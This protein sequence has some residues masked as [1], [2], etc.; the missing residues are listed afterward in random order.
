MLDM[1]KPIKIVEVA[2]KMLALYGRRDIEIRFV[3]IR[4]GEKLT[5][6]LNSQFENWHN[7]KFRKVFRV[8]SSLECKQD[9]HQWTV[10]LED[11]LSGL[12]NNQISAEMFNCLA[13]LQSSA[14]NASS[15]KQELGGLGSAG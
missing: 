5:E 15:Q 6:E 3:G 12:R 11:R 14:N 10:N 7:T 8:T 2:K 1:G 9:I 4:P 13:Q